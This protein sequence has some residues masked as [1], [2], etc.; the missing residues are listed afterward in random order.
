MRFRIVGGWVVPI[1]MLFAADPALSGPI[2]EASCAT[3]TIYATNSSGPVA[4]GNTIGLTGKYQNCSSSRERYF[5]DLSAVSS[6]AQ[7]VDIA[8]GR[9]T[10]DPGL[11]RIW[12]VSYTFPADTCSGPW[13]ATMQ[14]DDG[15]VTLATAS[16]TVTVGTATPAG[17]VSDGATMPG[18]PLLVE[19]AT[20]G[21]VWLT[22]GA[23]CSPD[24]TD[25]EVY[26]GTMDDFTQYMP[27]LCTTGGATSATLGPSGDNQFFLVVP[28]NSVHE[29]SYGTNS[30]GVERPPNAGACLSQ[31]SASCP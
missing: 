26:A 23:S 7:K 31:S 1:A 10:L 3:V 30:A 29:G 19:H 20:G 18:P 14:I 9:F 8:A 4:P 15:S 11:A 21:G 27:L 16:T 24:D 6:C 17:R 2:Q 5:Y 12:S 28:R 13:T 25:Y 22:W